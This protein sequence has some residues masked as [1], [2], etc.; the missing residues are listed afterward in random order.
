MES[1][2]DLVKVITSQK[3]FIT[4]FPLNFNL[5]MC[6]SWKVTSANLQIKKFSVT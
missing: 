1:Q 4:L 3:R 6:R 5:K 2:N